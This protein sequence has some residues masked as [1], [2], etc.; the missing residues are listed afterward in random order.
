MSSLVEVTLQARAAREVRVQY[1]IQT[2]ANWLVN[3]AEVARAESPYYQLYK[4]EEYGLPGSNNPFYPAYWSGPDPC[5]DET[6]IPI[7]MLLNGP[8]QGGVLPGGKTAIQVA[9]ELMGHVK[10]HTQF[11]REYRTFVVYAQFLN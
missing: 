5:P 1:L 7:V 3:K 11:K 8:K 2:L 4:I 9:N 10:F 6:G